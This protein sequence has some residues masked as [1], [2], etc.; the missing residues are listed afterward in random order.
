MYTQ[1]PSTGRRE[2][3]QNTDIWVLVFAGFSADA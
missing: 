3:M 2:Q 1:P